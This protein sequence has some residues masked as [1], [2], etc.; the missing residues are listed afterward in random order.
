MPLMVHCQRAGFELIWVSCPKT[1][2]LGL[3]FRRNRGSPS[4]QDDPRSALWIAAVDDFRALIGDHN[5]A[6]CA[7]LE[8]LR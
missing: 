1:G 7:G 3:G 5:Q 8:R 2:I 4:H 6:T